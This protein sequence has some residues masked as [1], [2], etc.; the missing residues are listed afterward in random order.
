MSDL[1][2]LLKELMEKLKE[3]GKLEFSEVL[4]WSERRGLTPLT[5]YLLFDE[6]KE[7]KDVRF[8]EEKELID[9]NLELYIPR[10]IE[11]LSSLNGRKE[12]L[13]SDKPVKVRKSLRKIKHKKRKGVK[14]GSQ[15]NLVG[16]LKEERVREG[17]PEK[18]HEPKAEEGV[19]EEITVSSEHTKPVFEDPD[20]AKAV[21]YLSRY[22]S[23]GEIRFI[24][25]LKRLGI[26][27]PR[28]V[29][30]KLLSEKLIS[31][32]KL[33]VINAE[34]RLLEIYKPKA[35]SITDIV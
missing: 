25:D 1:E 17:E 34:K 35:P 28:K 26:K 16:F 18:E 8:S 29:I 23:V 15:V 19:K 27:D 30:E 31:R 7:N 3:R 33:G 32:S 5:L 21:E 9:E 20:L 10:R 14:T 24:Q 22:W 13:E 12:V 2:D 4:S 11:H 6:L